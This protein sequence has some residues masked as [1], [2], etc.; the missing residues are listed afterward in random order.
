G[1]QSAVEATARQWSG[2]PL[3]SAD[4]FWNA[5]C[6]QQLDFFSGD[7]PL[8]RFS[9]KPT[10]ALPQVAGTH[11]WLVDWGGAQRWLRADGDLTEMEALASRAGGQVSLYRG[12]DRDGE[13]FHQQPQALIALQQR[14][15]KSFDPDALF[16]PGR[17]Y[18]WM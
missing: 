11:Q 14:I 2:E 17:L 16:N 6:Q 1:A 15:K 12:G 7:M 8:W 5:L 4:S 9:V 10:A 3:Q 18:S 13:V